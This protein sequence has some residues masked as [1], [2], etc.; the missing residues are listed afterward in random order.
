VIT[1]TAAAQP[2]LAVAR[3]AEAVMNAD[4]HPA[5]GDEDEDPPRLTLVLPGHLDG[6]QMLGDL[7]AAIGQVR[8]APG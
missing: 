5:L 2:D 6:D 4:E 1:L 7:V 3:V 8:T